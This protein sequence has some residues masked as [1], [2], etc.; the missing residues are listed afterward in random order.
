MLSGI[1]E[2]LD[3]IWRNTEGEYSDDAKHTFDA[4]VSSLYNLCRNNEMRSAVGKNITPQ[5]QPIFDNIPLSAVENRDEVSQFLVC[6]L[7]DLLKRFQEVHLLGGDE[8]EMVPLTASAV[9]AVTIYYLVIESAH[10]PAVLGLCASIGSEMPPFDDESKANHY[11]FDYREIVGDC[12]RKL[13]DA[14]DAHEC[15]RMLDQL[16]AAVLIYLL[17]AAHVEAAERLEQLIVAGRSLDS[18]NKVIETYESFTG[19]AGT[20]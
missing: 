10:C 15:L 7:S 16:D 8:D 5:V 6:Y 18:F 4:L 17:Q 1:V 13:R 2:C 3:Q 12:F 14:F 19:G 20:R 9:E 11:A